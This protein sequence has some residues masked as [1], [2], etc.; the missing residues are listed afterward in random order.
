MITGNQTTIVALEVVVLPEPFWE[1]ES[2]R[3][4]IKTQQV[5]L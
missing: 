5:T 2:R 4:S 1:M 3:N